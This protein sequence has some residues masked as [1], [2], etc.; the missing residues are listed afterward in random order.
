MT[1]PEMFGYDEHD[2]YALDAA[3]GCFKELS[4]AAV[5]ALVILSWMVLR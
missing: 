5:I 4:L 2:G 1:D 3:D